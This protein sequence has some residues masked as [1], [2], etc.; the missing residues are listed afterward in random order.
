MPR[1]RNRKTGVVVNVDDG[2]ASKLG[3]DW[4]AVEK[5]ATRPAVEDDGT[6]RGNA[7]RDEWAAYAESL[8][9]DV[10]DEAKRDEIKDLVTAAAEE[11]EGA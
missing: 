8:G 2:T 7:S 6:P 10:P 3:R 11:E 5:A 9:I 4:V 1:L